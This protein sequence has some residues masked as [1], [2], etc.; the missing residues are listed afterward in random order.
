MTPNEY[1]AAVYVSVIGGALCLIACIVVFALA[2]AA[3]VVLL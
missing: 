1:K 2:I 3:A